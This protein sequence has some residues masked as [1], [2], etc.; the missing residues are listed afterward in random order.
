MLAGGAA[1]VLGAAAVLL[2]VKLSSSRDSEPVATPAAFA[3]ARH[4][5]GPAGPAL[6]APPAVTIDSEAA[7]PDSAPLLSTEQIVTQSIPAVVTVVTPDGLGSGFF[8]ASDTVI[9]NA[10]VVGH[11]GR[12]TLRRG[13]AYSRTA[14]VHTSSADIDLAVLKLD[15]PDFDQA[16]LSL[17]G[18]NDVA[19]GADV[20]AIGSPLGLANTVTRGIVSGTR[21]MNGTNL[22]QTDA[23]INPGNSGGPL[24]DRRGRVL[25][26]NTMKLGRGVEGMAFA[27]SVE[28]V[29]MMLGA[30]YVRRSEGDER[31]EKG[32]IEY[33]ENM[34]ALSQ[35]TEAVDANWKA[36]KASCE[37][38][39]AQSIERQWF[40]FW[41]GRRARMRDSAS[42]LAWFGYFKESAVS[43]RNALQRHET[44]ARS[45][46][47]GAEQTRV[48]RRRMNM[49]FPEWEP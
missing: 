41:D 18:P 44:A 23:A 47:L 14:R 15:I 42:C 17:A 48:I 32:R 40:L 7:T 49:V 28:Y 2:V 12:V 33:T 19:V 45:M 29:P 20:V 11:H 24:L 35:R 39:D 36:F 13:G 37:A 1:V 6:G 30:A 21:R 3:D 43:A 38:A 10:H 22:I 5:Q 4:D 27:V 31:R 46:G 26:V 34:R 9:T 8:V 16:V 25:G